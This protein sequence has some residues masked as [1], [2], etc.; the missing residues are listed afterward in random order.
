M[1]HV[2]SQR[3]SHLEGLLHSQVLLRSTLP[4]NLYF[5]K[6]AIFPVWLSENIPYEKKKV[7]LFNILTVLTYCKKVVKWINCYMSASMRY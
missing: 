4:L 1:L 6:A 7:R 5:V 3:I 2:D